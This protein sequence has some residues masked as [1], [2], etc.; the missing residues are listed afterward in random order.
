MKGFILS[1]GCDIPFDTPSEN[2]NAIYSAV[3][4]EIKGFIDSK[5]SYDDVV[6][7]IPDYKNEEQVI[8]DVVTLDSGSCAPCQ[9]MV[10]AVRCACSQFYGRVK[11]TERKIKERESAAFALRMGVSN[12][13]SVLI[14][15]ELKYV[16]IIPAQDRL[17]EDIEAALSKKQHNF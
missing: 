14:D 2:I 7:H 10:E 17:K 1:P 5:A 16:S 15:G 3:H 11:W 6:V 9:Y 8:V 4:G 12:I 13:P